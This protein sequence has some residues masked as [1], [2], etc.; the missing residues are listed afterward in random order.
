MATKI[1]LRRDSSTN[2]TSNNPTLSSG[3]LGYET[4]TTQFKI[5]NGTDDWNTLGYSTPDMSAKADTTYVDAADALKAD[6]TYVDSADALKLDLAGGTMTGDL[7]LDGNTTTLGG[8]VEDYTDLGT[9]N[10][11]LSIDPSITT[12]FAATLDGDVVF[13]GFTNPAAGQGVSMIFTQDATGSRLLTTNTITAKF[14]M[15]VN[16]LSTAAAAIDIAHIFYDGSVYYLSFS[17]G[18]V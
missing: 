4:D 2:W 16:T 13:E 7:D 10:G 15:G 11:V 14:A 12:V 8:V 18:Y 3:E 9:V 1:Q 17:K 5:G 6:I